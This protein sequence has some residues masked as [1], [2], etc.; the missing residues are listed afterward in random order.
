MG[1][2]A[3]SLESRGSLKATQ[4]RLVGGSHYRVVVREGRNAFENSYS[5]GES[6]EAKVRWL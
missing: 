6:K 3:A 4:R 5:G 2:S 1:K